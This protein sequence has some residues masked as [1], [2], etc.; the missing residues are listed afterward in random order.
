MAS[1]MDLL[2]RFLRLALPKIHL[3]LNG[4]DQLWRL[5]GVALDNL[6]GFQECRIQRSAVKHGVRV[7]PDGIGQPHKGKEQF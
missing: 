7:S 2:S 6:A 5:A 3:H 1:W 4:V